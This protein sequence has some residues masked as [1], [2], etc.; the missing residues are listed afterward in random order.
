MNADRQ[1]FGVEGVKSALRASGL[2][3]AQAACEAVRDAV[4]AH[5]GSD[6]PHDDITLVAVQAEGAVQ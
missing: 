2:L 3:S 4:R 6:A 5:T 1:M